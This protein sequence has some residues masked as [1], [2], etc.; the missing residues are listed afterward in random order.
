M[1]EKENYSYDEMEKIGDYLR[2]DARRYN[3]DIAEEDE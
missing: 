1:T 3:A 2:L